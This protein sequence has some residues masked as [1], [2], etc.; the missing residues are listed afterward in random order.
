M[1]SKFSIRFC[2]NNLIVS[3]VKMY[4]R[5]C[6]FI[7]T[8]KINFFT[9]FCYLLKKFR[10]FSFELNKRNGKF[11]FDISSMQEIKIRFIHNVIKM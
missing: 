7:I 10:Y 8:S 9:T 11:E 5:Y 3:K 2:N 1:I 4:E 6:V